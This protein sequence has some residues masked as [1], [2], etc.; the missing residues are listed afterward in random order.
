MGGCEM[1]DVIIRLMGLPQDVEQVAAILRNSTRFVEESK[2]YPNRGASKLVRRYI[3][4]EALP[5]KR[6]LKREP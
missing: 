5:R 1:A 4:L 6:N 3:T 2:D